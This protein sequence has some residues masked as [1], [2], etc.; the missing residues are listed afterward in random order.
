[1]AIASRDNE[2]M[3]FVSIVSYACTIW[4]KFIGAGQTPCTHNG[5]DCAVAARDPIQK[6][7]RNTKSL[8]FMAANVATGLQPHNLIVL[9]ASLSAIYVLLSASGNVGVSHV[10]DN[11]TGDVSRFGASA[12]GSALSPDPPDFSSY[13]EQS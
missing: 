3:R 13:G 7:G 1:M 10:G 2:A 12:L 8:I 5:D 4:E 6:T 9:N 11:T